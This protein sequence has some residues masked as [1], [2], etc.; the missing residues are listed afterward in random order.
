VQTKPLISLSAA[1]VCYNSPSL[2]LRKLLTSLLDSIEQLGQSFELTP[3]PIYLIDD[4]DENSLEFDILNVFHGER[5][6]LIGVELRLVQGQGN[7]GYGG[8][9][10]LVISEL[11][12]H[13]H[14]L[15]NPDVVLQKETPFAALSAAAAENSAGNANASRAGG[16]N[17]ADRFTPRRISPEDVP[18]GMRVVSTP[19]GD[20]LVDQ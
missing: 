12:S 17:G 14:L 6:R 15:L 5:L 11:S 13:F 18:P 3:I 9:H 7:V 20:R 16:R 19:F 1:V 2:E 4:S 8:A 10:N